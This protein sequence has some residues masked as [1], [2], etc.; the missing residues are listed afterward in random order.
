MKIDRDFNTDVPNQEDFSESFL[1]TEMD[2]RNTLEVGFY[3]GG[4]GCSCVS[5]ESFGRFILDVST[6]EARRAVRSHLLKTLLLL[7]EMEEE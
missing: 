7:D 6:P 5:G 2:G 1:S 4:W 3:Q